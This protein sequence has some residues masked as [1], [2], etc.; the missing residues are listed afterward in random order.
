M[1]TPN[2]DTFPELPDAVIWFRFVLAIVYGLH[3]GLSATRG[4][5]NL[6]FGLNVITFI[7]ILYCQLILAADTDSYRHLTFAGVSNSLA[8]LLLIWMYFYSVSH[9]NEEAQL[10]AALSAMTGG[11]MATGEE[12]NSAFETA[13]TSGATTV[14]TTTPLMEEPVA[15]VEEET[16]F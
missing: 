8:L 16:E 3:L 2:V 11:T 5:A 12:T 10:S 6:I 1:K 4:A 7:P 14:D 9:A 15:P 13:A